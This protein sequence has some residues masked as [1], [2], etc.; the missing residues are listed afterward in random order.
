MTVIR[1]VLLFSVLKIEQIVLLLNLYFFV[2]PLDFYFHNFIFELQQRILLHLRQQFQFLIQ[3]S[4]QI[5]H[6]LLLDV[7]ALLF[8]KFTIF[9]RPISKSRRII[10]TV[11]FKLIFPSTTFPPKICRS[12]VRLKAFNDFGFSSDFYCFYFWSS[13]FHFFFQPFCHFINNIKKGNNDTSF[14]C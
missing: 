10:F 13:F 4:F 3:S 11:L 2:S 5:L 7:F 6:L 1:E 8:S 14:F 9:P 12:F